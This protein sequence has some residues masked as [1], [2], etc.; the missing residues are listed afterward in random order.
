MKKI[1]EPRLLFLFTCWIILFF[2]TS[3]ALF[4]MKIKFLVMLSKTP[5]CK[6]QTSSR[7]W[8]SAFSS[9]CSTA[10]WLTFALIIMFL[11]NQ[12]KQLHQIQP[13]T[14]LV[15]VTQVKD[16]TPLILVQAHYVCHFTKFCLL[17]KK[18]HRDKNQRFKT[19]YFISLYGKSRIY[20]RTINKT[21]S[22]VQISHLNSV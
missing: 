21:F 14:A 8:A 12:A 7:L 1:L 9:N 11:P 13:H 4:F 10:F 20:F 18:R 15:Q 16:L 6:T 3:W 17:S 22:N 2:I 19:Q 5:N